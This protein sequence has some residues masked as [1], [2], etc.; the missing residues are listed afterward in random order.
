MIYK[1]AFH[2]LEMAQCVIQTLADVDMM[3]LYIVQIELSKP[4]LINPRIIGIPVNEHFFYFIF[5]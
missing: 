1:L 2:G 5:C 3:S 4:H